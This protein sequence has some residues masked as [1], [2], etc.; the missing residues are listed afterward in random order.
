MLSG[1]QAQERCVGIPFGKA[2]KVS[3]L[4]NQRQ[5]SMCA[6][7]E[8]TTQILCIFLI[9]FLSCDLFDSFIVTFDFCFLFFIGSQVFI[10]CFTIHWLEFQLS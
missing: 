1:C 7:S 3:G 4:H 10:K 6:D 9:A 5:C 2:F 8:E